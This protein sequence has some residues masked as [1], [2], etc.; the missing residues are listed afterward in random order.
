MENI[1]SLRL[2][3]LE[4]DGYIRYSAKKNISLSFSKNLKSW[5]VLKRDILKPR[6]HYFDSSPLHT[7]NPVSTDQGILLIYF[8]KKRNPGL[9]LGVALF[10]KEDPSKLLWRSA[11]KVWKTKKKLLPLHV[12]TKKDHVIVYFRHKHS[13]R[14]AAKI[15]IPLNFIFRKEIDCQVARPV[16]ERTITNP[17]LKP[18]S[19]NRWES[20][21][22]FNSTALY[23]DGKIHILYRAMSK[24]STST[25]G[26]ATSKNGYITEERW[27][28]P[29]YSPREDFEMK[30]RP[31]NSGCE[32]PRLTRLG[33]KIYLTYTAYNGYNPPAVALSSIYVKDFLEKKWKWKKPILLSQPG[34]A[35][36]NW[37]FF[38]QKINGKYAILHSIS[39]KI[40]VKYFDNLEF[41]N[42]TPIK[43]FHCFGS[44]E[45]CWDDMVRGAGPP[46]IR[47]KDGWLVIYHAMSTQDPDRYKLGAMLLDHDD[48][49]EIIGRLPYPLLEPDAKYENEGFKAGVVYACGAVIID[50]RL[51]VYYGGADMV[52]C[53]ATINLNQLLDALKAS[54]PIELEYVQT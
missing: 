5:R 11:N 38:P 50:D 1:K 48:P 28:Y 47:T 52:T 32:D 40:R 35:N 51:F 53:V 24:N 21:A 46:P 44:R 54:K 9:S 8:M 15:A 7:L 10:D 45:N 3:F 13:G 23:L 18:K 29:I 30:K 26:Y 2:N 39:P 20:Q 27:P 17:I 25:L 12:E 37:V 16:F 42:Y 36:K 49:T 33:D 14:A 22:T 41:N 4:K 19:K 43:S 31:G 6:K 34:Q